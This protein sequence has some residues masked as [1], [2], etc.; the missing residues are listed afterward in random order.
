[1]EYAAGLSIRS[2]SGD[3]SG[4]HKL[5]QAKTFENSLQ[6]QTKESIDRAG[7]PLPKPRP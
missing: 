3:G 1:M 6:K 2:K 5:Q 4:V 7:A